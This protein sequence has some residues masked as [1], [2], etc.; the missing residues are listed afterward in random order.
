ML[1]EMYYE[2]DFLS[3]E[4]CLYL[5]QHYKENEDK[6]KR[7][8]CGYPPH[9]RINFLKRI[10]NVLT[11][12]KTDEKIKQIN[13]KVFEAVKRVNEDVF[14]FDI[15]YEYSSNLEY[16]TIVQYDGNEKAFWSKQAHVNWISNNMQQKLFVSI[17]LSAQEEFEGGDVIYYFGKHQDRPTPKEHRQ[18]GLLTIF[19]SFRATQTMPVLS[20]V[21]YTYDFRFEGPC[22]K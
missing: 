9:R 3:N 8:A 15:D 6:I 7:G 21:K 4:E 13:E 14:F 10:S 1:A 17:T 2:P 12:D 5:I 16:P 11:V 20:G 18:R 22:W 19:P